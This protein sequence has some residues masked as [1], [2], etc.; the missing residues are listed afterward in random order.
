MTRAFV[1]TDDEVVALAAIHN[2]LWPTGLATVPT[3]PEAMRDAGMRGIRSLMVRGLV[4]GEF[5]PN[6]RYAVDPELE[7]AVNGFLGATR[8]VGAYLAPIGEPDRLA[9]AA[10][11]AAGAGSQ[12]WLVNTT[13]HGVHSIRPSSRLEVIDALAELAEKTYDGTLLA[14]SSDPSDYACVVRFGPGAVDRIVFAGNGA[15]T[16]P[17]WN[18][19]QLVD[20]F[21]A[22]VG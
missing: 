18:R 13:A 20:A 1:L 16:G 3:A 12:W 17:P 4:G 22:A 7:S 9:G 19:A 14:A 15:A 21:T 11:T 10:I 6:G 8:R 5:G 2:Q